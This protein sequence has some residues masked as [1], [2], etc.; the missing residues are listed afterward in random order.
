LAIAR[1]IG[2]RRHEGRTLNNIAAIYEAKGDYSAALKQYEQAL[3]I[4]QEIGDKDGEA[5]CRWNIGEGYIKQGD[6]DK[7]EPYLSRAVEL[8]TQLERPDLKEWR[9]KLEEIRAKLRP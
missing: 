3:A 6:L 7:A 8:G 4:V 5:S 2:D 1:Q 9:E